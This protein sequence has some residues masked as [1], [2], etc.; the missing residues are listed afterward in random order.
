MGSR[1][2]GPMTRVYRP[3]H[4]QADE[5]VNQNKSIGARE[6]LLSGLEADLVGPFYPPGHPGSTEEVLRLP[7]SR[8][9]LTGFLAPE[10]DRET[11]DP[12]AEEDFTG[13]EDEP[14]ETA[15]PE[16]EP[17]R[18]HRFPASMGMSVLLPAEGPGHVSVG[19]RF[20]EY[21]PEKIEGQ[22]RAVWR[23]MPRQVES[24]T[25]PL[26]PAALA[27]GV[28]I[29]EG[30]RIFLVG[31]LEA[32]QAPG[33]EDGARAL[34]LF[35]VNRRQPREETSEQDAEFLFQVELELGYGGGLLPRPNRR[36]E[37]AADWDDQVADLQFRDRSE[38]AVGHGVSVVVPEGAVDERGRAG[39]V[40]TT[41]LPR[42]EVPRVRPAAPPEGSTVAME[43][44]A[45]LK[46]GAEA[47]ER[48][49]PIVDAYGKWLKGQAAIAVDSSE[50]EECRD[51]LVSRAETA[52]K[53]IRSGI[54]RL[55]ADPDVLD[56]FRLTNR[57]MAEAALRRSPDRYYDDKRPEWRLFQLA[58][59]LLNLDGVADPTHGDRDNVEL[60]FFPTGGGKTEAYLGVIAFTL[61]L[62]RIRGQ[63]R[64]DKG[65]GVAVLLR[66]TLR[67][68][69]LDQLGRAAT[70]ICALEVLRRRD[71]K[72]LGQE[73]FAVGLWVGMSATANTLGQ[74]KKQ[75]LEYKNSAAKNASSPFPLAECPWCRTELGKD[76]LRL[77]PSASKTEGIV[78]GCRNFKCDF[79]ARRSPQGLPVLFVD[80][81]IYTELPAF[82]VGTV[83]KFAMLPW[84]GETGKLFGRVT[85]RV[86]T[87][88][89]GHGF[90]G[91]VDGK[92][93]NAKLLPDGLKPPELIVQDE[94]HLISGPLGT[95]VG[96]YETAI[97]FLSTHEVNG[98][99]VRPKVLAST[100]TVRRASEQIQALFARKHV[101]VFPPPGVD[102]SESYF[103]EVDHES[104]GRLYVGVAAQARSMKG[105]LLR[106]Y[107]TAL[108]AA[109][110]QYEDL[111]EKAADPYMTVA[112]YFNSL[113]E[114][115]GMRRLVEDEVR[116]RCEQ[117]EERVPLNRDGP[118]PWLRK[119]QVQAEPVELTSREST[120]KIKESKDRLNKP[121]SDK[122]H[123]D[124]LLASNMISVGV[125]I[126]RL[127]LMV[128]AGQPKTTAEYIQASS[129]VGRQHPGLV[130]TC[131][132]IA[133]PRDRSHYE[134]F[135]AYH[136]SFYRFVEANSLT[137]FSTRALERGLVG[138]LMA[139]TRLS[140][141]E[142]TPAGG[143]MAIEAHRDIADAAVAAI[144]ERAAAHDQLTRAE[145]DKL[146]S[147]LQ[148]RG[149]HLVDLWEKIVKQAREE[150]AARRRYSKFDLDKSAGKPILMLALDDAG[151]R[152]AAEREFVAPTSMRDVEPQVHLWLERKRSLGAS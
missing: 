101:A 37:G 45:E 52:R 75:V 28:P 127:G 134:R 99:P 20:A 89:G 112:G 90:F 25:V 107:T 115:G 26:E 58:F 56:A 109:Q 151:D 7:P 84:R 36:G 105:I 76:S 97:D 27:K 120:G 129:R 19:V 106:T 111:G 79:S 69:T 146:K 43:V 34:S 96:L 66:Y 152:S 130:L 12:T 70:L 118:H 53:R 91:P 122:E 23:R 131:F 47:R 13:L 145:A 60:I 74:L 31:H 35:L 17:K 30:E 87:V 72:R 136:E 117:I 68:L 8:W 42:Y 59:V 63:A 40:K 77:V 140:N 116:S 150:G 88:G 4:A 138:S 135:T 48:L 18:R 44:L 92:P 78:V 15:A 11:R 149:S 1:T 123:V 82:V 16:P 3:K 139:M 22:R 73:R 50:R 141:A 39:S 5:A 71:T 148:E 132:N 94:L 114:L 2:L 126:D 6:A 57:A 100:A 137:P 32:A 14:E 128:V 41:W 55:A 38:Y 21:V 113:R 119:R 24:I 54:E 102:D 103:A 46:D 62:R 147:Y 83:D 93:R 86:E 95:M 67:L 104:P 10:Q 144:A 85:G 61:L 98:K 51:E 143:A 81:Q 133:K 64:P 125:D 33:L 108:T 65:L 124:V 80:E 142:L 49:M 110:K 121:H 29:A 9:Y